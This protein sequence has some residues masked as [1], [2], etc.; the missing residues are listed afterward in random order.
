M[1]ENQFH[2]GLFQEIL[3]SYHENSLSRHAS[4]FKTYKRPH[5]VAYWPGM[6]TDVKNFIKHCAVCQSLKADNQK[7]AGKI[8][9]P[10]VKGPTE[11]LCI[12]INARFSPL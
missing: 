7:P 8:Q 9:Q 5:E 10:T 6:W 2:Y 12:N 4:I 3:Q 11:M 1:S